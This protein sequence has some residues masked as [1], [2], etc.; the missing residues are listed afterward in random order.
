M[1]FFSLDFKLQLRAAA[2]GQADGTATGGRPDLLGVQLKRQNFSRP[3]GWAAMGRGARVVFSPH[4][5][6]RRQSPS[7]LP[8]NSRPGVASVGARGAVRQCL[9]GGPPNGRG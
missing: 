8:V 6:G 2:A 5:S 9:L 3:P 7:A 4:C 1:R